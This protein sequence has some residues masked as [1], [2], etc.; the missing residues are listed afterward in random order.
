MG[1]AGEAY[2][3]QPQI[4]F[5][6]N[7]QRT[8]L[9]QRAQQR[10]DKRETFQSQFPVVKSEAIFCGFLIETQ[11]SMKREELFSS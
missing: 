11:K 6:T 3:F 2:R 10:P 4:N 8:L 9:N 1:L 7:Y 5:K